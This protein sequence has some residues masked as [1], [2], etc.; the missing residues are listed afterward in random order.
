MRKWLRRIVAT[1][2]VILIVA[3]GGLAIAVSYTADC[4]SPSASTGTGPRMKAVTRRCYGS[5]DVLA[6]EDLPRPE[7]KGNQLLVRVRAAAINPLDWHEIRGTPYLI[8][9]AE[10]IGA[11][12]DPHLGI[13]FAGVVEAVGSEVTKF[14]PGDEIFGG[15]NGALAEYILVRE[16]GSIAHKPANVS[17]EQAAGTY[18]A[19][20]TALQA[21]RDRG[22]IRPGDKVLINGASGGV[23]TFAVQIAKSMGADVTGVCSTRNVELVRS[24]GAQRVVDYTKED[25]TASTE[26]FDVIMDNVVN[27]PLLD[28]RKVLKPRGKY[29]A[30]GGGGPDENPWIGAFKAPIKAAVISWFVDQD[31]AFFLSHASTED[32]VALARLMEQGKVTTVVDRR[33]PLVD[34]QEA[35]R[36]LETGRARGKVVLTMD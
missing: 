7:P 32:V 16:T 17:F 3:L 19:G 18:V 13:D 4:Q 1:F 23:G 6:V 30:I 36:Y 31:M 14:R 34:I 20:L 33:Y 21:L 28:I 24:L 11:P 29:L 12:K 25:F 5:P 9:M 35:V 2:G 26:R 8:R 22:A 10:G 15:R 27:R